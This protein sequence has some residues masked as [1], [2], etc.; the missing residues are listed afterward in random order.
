MRIP[1]SWLREHVDVPAD[2]TPDDIHA[3]LVRV[4]FEEEAV[5][6]ADVTGPLVVGRILGFDEEEHSNGKTIRWVQVD[7]GEAEP[8]GIVCGARN[9]AVDDLVVVSLPGAVLPG[10]FAISARK[11][12]GHVSD[13]MI[14]SERELGLG[15]DH[16]GI[17]VLEAGVA[18]P[19]ADALALLGLDDAAVEINVTPDRGYALSIRGVAREY[20]LATGQPFVDPAAIDA[21]NASGFP[22]RIA[23]DAPIR[24]AVGCG[25]F[26]ARVVR[27]IDATRPTPRWMSSRLELAG[28]RSLSLPI[29]I[30]NY[31]MVELGQPIHGYDL[32]TL[33]GGITVRRAHEG[34]RL[35]T[36]DGAERAL[37]IEDLL[38]TDESGPIGIAGV[39]G[40]STTEM[41]DATTDVLVEAAWFEPVTIAR[42][43]R[44]H[45][46]WSEASK[47]FE[48]GVDTALQHAAA[49]RVADLL[50]EL[51]GGTID[52]LGAA[53]G[54][55]PALGAVD[56]QPDYAAVRTGADY[57]IDESRM[58]LEGIGATIAE[59]GDRWS[60]TPPSWRPDLTE[61][62]DLA[63]EV[64]RLV[65]YDRIPSVLPVAPPGRGLTRAQRLRRRVA[66]ALA[67]SGLTEVLVAPFLTA[68]QI[69]MTGADAIRLA[70]ALDAQRPLLRTSL[71][72]GLVETAQRNVGRGLV[73]LAIFEIGSVFLPTGRHGTD[74]VPEGPAL[75]TPETLATLDD[76]PAQPRRV[77]ALLLGARVPRQPGQQREAF[78][79]ADAIDAARR[80]ARTAGLDVTVRQTQRDWLHPGRAA[81]V[82]VGDV[83]VGVAG[84]LLPAIASEA[85]LPRQVAV[86]E[87]DLDLVVELA[88]TSLETAT[89]ASTPAATQDL[90]VVVADGV[91][92][93]DVLRAVR[94]GAGA[95]L[96]HIALVDDYRGDDLDGAKSLTFA[97]RFRDA[98]RTLT[99]AEATEAKLAGLA[100]AA[101]RHGAVLRE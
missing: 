34:E 65:G 26:V 81:E 71:V 39:M 55:P 90:S 5:H 83:V 13:G 20:A 38:I 61:R 49:Q 94:E 66:D 17:L 19:G 33:A 41:T 28:V 99:A 9:F 60:V 21:P 36:L 14:A 84:E 32:A 79:V 101:A 52:D 57:S 73:D 95:L 44:R 63:E 18:A 82:L 62:D 48:R 35:T 31:V 3:A 100:V 96:E 50:V 43:A 53:V 59:V 16:E 51:A 98:A 40:G 2:A 27:G 6:G 69:A 88:R 74:A 24:G 25:R 72:P 7:A 10:G 76:L 64:A 1:I 58:A 70:N 68:A 23:D 8:R 54:E 92:A 85:D 42:S 22:V 77:G 37:S 30:T 75:P 29:D 4:G 56:Y 80:V 87:L 15:D 12:Y 67:S 78:G 93:G 46:L 45:R 97:L 86:L 11:T 91:P 89:I 47:R